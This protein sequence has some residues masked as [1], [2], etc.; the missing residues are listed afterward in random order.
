MRRPARAPGRVEH[1]STY[2]RATL[3]GRARGA[4]DSRDMTVPTILL[5]VALG[6][7]GLLGLAMTLCWA[8]KAGDEEA[9]YAPA[10]R[11]AAPQRRHAGG[12]AI[13]TVP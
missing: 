1:A 9:G 3:T 6:W 8:A 11:P 10:N 2:A 5:L 13:G 4:D 7:L 12:P